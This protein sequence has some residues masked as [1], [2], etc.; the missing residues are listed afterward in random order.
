MM[1]TTFKVSDS[2]KFQNKIIGEVDTHKSELGFSFIDKIEIVI[3]FE[4][5]SNGKNLRITAT[6][7]EK[8]VSD[9]NGELTLNVSFN[10]TIHQGNQAVRITI[11]LAYEIK[12]RGDVGSSI[13][14]LTPNGKFIQ[15]SKTD[16]VSDFKDLGTMST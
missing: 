9:Q 7:L 13:L 8:V 4:F 15:Y 16:N 14:K 1:N 5:E 11:N 12:N 6:N 3:S 10:N 2:Y